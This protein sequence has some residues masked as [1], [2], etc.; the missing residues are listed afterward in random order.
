MIPHSFSIKSASITFG[1][2]FCLF[3]TACGEKKS[4]ATADWENQSGADI[5]EQP[6]KIPAVTKQPKTDVVPATSNKAMGVRFIAYNL[7]NYLT[8]RRYVD[9]KSIEGGKPEKEIEALLNVIVSGKPDILGVCEIGSQEDLADFQKRLGAKGIKLPH[10]HRVQGSDPTRAL[11]IL[12]KYPV[13]AHP[14]PEKS[15]YK[16]SG[17][18]FQISR[19][20]LDVSINIAGKDVRFLGI[21]LKSKRP[22]RDADQEMMRRNEAG[23]VRKHIETILSTT[24]EARLLVYGDYNDTKRTKSVY[25]I[26]GRRNSDK[27]LEMLEF[28]DSRGE[29]WTHHWKR[30]DIY[31]R[32]DFCMTS[33]S[34]AP[35]IKS[36]QCRLLDPDYWETGSDHRAMLLIFK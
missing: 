5:T 8:M 11:A 16:L 34:L 24:P 21:H 31:S 28:P 2:F 35:H 12:S 9:G 20:I 14:K 3:L 17:K 23:L 7:R 1:A 36:E 27:R 6:E 18:E 30:E 22:V 26:Q 4:A 32:I 15:T 10:I 33:P 13:T 29:V 19:G 25:I